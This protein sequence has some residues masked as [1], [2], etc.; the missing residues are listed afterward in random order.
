VG[1]SV[2]VFY[3]PENPEKATI[4]GEGRVFRIIFMTVG[5]VIIIFGLFMFGSNIKNSYLES[6]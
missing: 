2:Q 6:V 1:E 5:G 3:S 4:K